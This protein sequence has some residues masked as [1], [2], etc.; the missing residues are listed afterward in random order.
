MTAND[1][2]TN[3]N[4]VKNV[5]AGDY[6][7]LGSVYT[8]L[9]AMTHHTYQ[10]IYVIDYFKKNFLY[11][12]GSPFFLCGKTP[13]VVKKE[14]YNFFLRHVPEEEIPLLF[15]MNKM[16]LRQYYAIAAE[17]R[18][19]H[20]ISYNFHL[21]NDRSSF[22]VNRRFTPLALAK[23]GQIWLALCV[24]SLPS[25]KEVGCLEMYRNQSSDYFYRY[26]W[27]LRH[28]VQCAS[29]VL[30]DHERNILILSAQGL[31][32]KEIAEALFL[33]ENTIKSYKKSLFKKLGVSN[34]VEAISRAYSRRL[35]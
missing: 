28:W 29:E 8:I 6:K 31:T 4:M 35:I 17:E 30:T 10:S 23:D 11:V 27:E 34:I 24:M 20:T 33:G 25:Y 12:S 19:H 7:K 14:G 1:F 15:E 5:A 3:M 16:L 9:N 22:L 21:N 18:L 2:F 26:S 32:M 13:E